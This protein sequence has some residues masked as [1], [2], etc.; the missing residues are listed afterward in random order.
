M[1]MCEPHW[2]NTGYGLKSD[3]NREDVKAQGGPPVPWNT[4]PYKKY[5]NLANILEDEPRHPKYNS[6]SRN[7]LVNSRDVQIWLRGNVDF[8]EERVREYSRIEDN[9]LAADEPGF[10]DASKMNFGLKAD[11]IV[12]K[13]IPD[14]EP[15]PFE[16]IGLQTD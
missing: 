10:I 4:A 13:K 16:L 12:Y 15:I 7:V 6:A 5:P 1:E 2:E 3:P 8:G 14:F 11:S 9:F